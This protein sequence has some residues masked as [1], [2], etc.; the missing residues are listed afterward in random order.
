MKLNLEVLTLVVVLV[1]LWTCLISCVCASI[2]LGDN[3]HIC[4]SIC[5]CNSRV[6][7][8]DAEV[9]FRYYKPGE[10]ELTTDTLTITDSTGTFCYAF[11]DSLLEHRIYYDIVKE[12]YIT[13]RSEFILGNSTKLD[14]CLRK[15]GE[16]R[17]AESYGI[18][19]NGIVRNGQGD[20]LTEATVD[21]KI[22]DKIQ[23]SP[24]KMTDSRGEFSWV[25][26][27]RFLGRRL[28]WKISKD[29]YSDSKGDFLIEGDKSLYVTLAP[30][31]PPP[32]EKTRRSLKRDILAGVSLVGMYVGMLVL[33]GS[34]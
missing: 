9:Y 26:E 3:I 25:F 21:A 8:T 33:T 13:L 34:I 14:T 27:S 11:S 17:K 22:D 4:G 29:R 28:N 12:R 6:D 19:I 15:I 32:K 18:F 1:I 23:L 10:S 20:P 5:D 30:L 16:D 31:L 7:I 24:L 2:C